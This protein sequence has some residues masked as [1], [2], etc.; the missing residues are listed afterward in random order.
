MSQL[1]AVP[2][3][4]CSLRSRATELVE[5]LTDARRRQVPIGTLQPV[6]G[7]IDLGQAWCR[8]RPGV[9]ELVL[10]ADE[11]DLCRCEYAGDSSPS[12][13]RRVVCG[14]ASGPDVALCLLNTPASRR[15]TRADAKEAA[16]A[17]LQSQE[18]Q[19]LLRRHLRSVDPATGK[20]RRR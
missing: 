12:Q 7:G 11:P 18:G 15:A 13:G 6:G 10:R 3:L 5:A 9:V 17:R 19:P 8:D 4:E 2:A 16:R 1:D 20:E 14:P